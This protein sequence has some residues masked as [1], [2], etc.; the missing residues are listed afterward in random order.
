MGTSSLVVDEIDAGAEFLRRLNPYRPVVAACWLHED[1]SQERYLH[2]ALD[3]L[4]T[5]NSD[6]AYLEVARIADEMTDYYID[7]FR[8]K[9]IRPDQ[10]VAKAVLGVYRRY[11]GRVPPRSDGSVFADAVEVYIYPPVQ[12]L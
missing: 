5:E 9:L 7:P 8:V 3:G 10:P 12:R 4:T 2:V 6:A 11:P 1:V